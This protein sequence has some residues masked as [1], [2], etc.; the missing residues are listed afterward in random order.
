MLGFHYFPDSEHYRNEDLVT[1]L[2][3]LQALGARWITLL[4]SPQRA[5][6]EAFLR[7]LLE[8]GIQ[9]VVH[10]PLRPESPLQEECPPLLEAYARW[11]VRYVMLFER[12]NQRAQ[13]ESTD[14][15]R[16]NV[17]RHFIQRLRP[18]AEQAA[19][20]GLQVIFP[21]LEPGS[22]Y[23][24]TAFLRA[25]LEEIQAQSP[26]LLES[27]VISALAH[28]GD[29]PLNWGAGGP[30]RWPGARAYYTPPEE[31]DQCGFAIA[32]WY[33]AITQAVCGHRLPMML[34]EAGSP[35]GWNPSADGLSTESHRKR[36]LQLL[37]AVNTP[38]TA[39][40]EVPPLPAEVLACHFHAIGDNLP[41]ACYTSSGAP[42]P[43][44]ARFLKQRKSIPVP[45]KKSAPQGKKPP[46]RPLKHYVLL[47]PEAREGE[48]WHTRVLPVLLSMGVTI[49]FSA[50]EAALASQVTVL[51][52]AQ[53]FPDALLEKLRAAGCRV[54]RLSGS[55][56]EVAT[57]LAQTR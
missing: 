16:F 46:A 2:P 11:G 40:A 10:L 54:V 56:T 43:L 1:W 33:A 23:W 35:G 20:N 5:I 48:T 49:G 55:G 3:R 51:G 45:A 4:S 36:T 26:A 27:L 34:F 47:P 44:G 57:F 30:E 29:N 9:V 32:D 25:A 21:P 31:Q 15:A 38:Q 37:Q 53:V 52:D 19:E 24:D 39:P 13:W 14:W 41:H 17:V 6:P 50:R 7:P 12:P 18:L 28:A 8:A 22:D 42:T